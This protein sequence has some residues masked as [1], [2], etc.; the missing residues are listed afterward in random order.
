MKRAD[1][2]F[3]GPSATPSVDHVILI[4]VQKK[5]RCKQSESINLDFQRIMLGEFFSGF[6][7]EEKVEYYIIFPGG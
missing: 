7:G 1:K 5:T 6:S 4:I 2:E 3:P